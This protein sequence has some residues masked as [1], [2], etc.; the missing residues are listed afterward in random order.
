MFITLS[1]G[2]TLA[3]GN[4]SYGIPHQ[5]HLYF[6]PAFIVASFLC[7]L[8]NTL[9]LNSFLDSPH[10]YSVITQVLTP[11]F[12]LRFITQLFN[13]TPSHTICLSLCSYSAQSQSRLGLNCAREINNYRLSV[14]P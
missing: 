6:K 1:R 12:D 9:S 5:A 13:R 11:S 14:I 8:L 10:L 3:I 4:H 2:N 7:L